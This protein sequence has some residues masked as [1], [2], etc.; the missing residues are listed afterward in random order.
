MLAFHGF[1]NNHDYPY[2]LIDVI[3]TTAG[4][5]YELTTTHPQCAVPMTVVT[6]RDKTFLTLLTRARGRHSLIRV[7]AR[8]Q[9]V[10]EREGVDLLQLARTFA[11]TVNP[12]TADD[13]RDVQENTVRSAVAVMERCDD[14][15]GDGSK[16]LTDIGFTSEQAKRLG[17]AARAKYLREQTLQGKQPKN[18]ARKIGKFGSK[19]GVREPLSENRGVFRTLADASTK[20][21]QLADG[22]TQ[23]W[24]RRPGVTASCD[25]ANLSE[26][27]VLIGC[28]AEKQVDFLSRLLCADWNASGIANALFER[29][30][31]DRSRMTAGDVIV[32]HSGTW[33]VEQVGFRLIAP[34]RKV[35]SN[36][37]AEYIVSQPKCSA[38]SLRTQFAL[39][40]TQAERIMGSVRQFRSNPRLG[41]YW[42]TEAIRRGVRA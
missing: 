41:V 10:A 37:I 19:S 31:V 29:K 18:R 34:P 23:V 4:K 2:G 8:A 12:E 13:M 32:N 20:F 17:I 6:D 40:E 39:S 28:V 42:L 15:S 11:G 21:P 35:P 27:H 3:D 30:G 33:L 36:Q 5:E 7:T 1:T 9:S 24:Y 14:G 16:V 25:P 38:L 26:T 22:Q